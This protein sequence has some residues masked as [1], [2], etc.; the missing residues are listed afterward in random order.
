M[1]GSRSEIEPDDYEARCNYYARR[2][3]AGELVACKQVIAACR[4]HLDDVKASQHESYPY[5]FN[6]TLLYDGKND[7]PGNRV[8]RFAE[9]MPHVKGI[10]AARRQKIKLEDWQVFLLCCLFGWVRKDTGFRRFRKALW[11]IPRKNA[12]STLA[13]I[14]GLYMFCADNEFGAE[15]YS[16]ATSEDQ[17]WEV[18]RPARQMVERSPKFSERFGIEVNAKSLF[19]MSDGSRFRPVIG[20]PG[21]GSS[22]SC[23][24]HDEYHEHATDDQVSTMETGMMAREQPLQLIVTTAGDNLSGPCYYAVT[25]GRKMLEGAFEQDDLFYIEYTIDDD[26]DWA[27]MDALRMANPNFGVSVFEDNMA[28]RLQEAKNSARKQGTFQT[29]HLNRWVGSR[30]AYFNVRRWIELGDE[31]LR[32]EDFAG[33]TAFAGLD[34]ATRHDIVNKILL[35]PPEVEG[36]KYTVFCRSYLPE[37]TV[38]KSENEHYHGWARENWLT[39][40]EGEVTDHSVVKDDIVSDS[41]VLQLREVAYDPAQANMMAT[42]LMEAGVTVVEVRPTVLNFSEPMKDLDALIR[43][44]SIQHNGDPVLTWMMSNVVAKEDAKDNVYPRKE[45]P[46][47]KID[48]AVALIM[49]LSRARVV[50]PRRRS[51]YNEAVI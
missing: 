19:R 27:T 40:T 20:K 39:V 6:P 21:D 25:A 45:R 34:L 14:I 3:V 13:S 50:K 24:I 33:R 44:G 31:S 28:S 41:G 5:E 36:E 18:F 16:G 22:P 51:I 4:R 38:W 49:A 17:A 43:S 2:V 46:E 15:V 37:E 30:S 32:L 9:M 8:C 7:R 23:A 12:K 10:W 26:T 1:A 11:L 47:N 29:K 35:F 42:E 48:G